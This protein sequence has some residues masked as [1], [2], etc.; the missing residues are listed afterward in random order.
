M[1]PVDWSCG[2][3]I[4]T[5]QLCTAGD[6]CCWASLVEFVAIVGGDRCGERAP[7]EVACGGGGTCALAPSGDEPDWLRMA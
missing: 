4:V 2:L 7:A 3:V 5:C 6:T 1:A